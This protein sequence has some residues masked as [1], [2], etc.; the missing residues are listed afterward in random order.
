MKFTYSLLFY[1][2][3]CLF[4]S[5]CDGDLI[6]ISINPISLKASVIDTN[7]LSK[8]YSVKHFDKYVE[9]PVLQK[10]WLEKTVYHSFSSPQSEDK[11]FVKVKG[12]KYY[13]A[14]IYFSIFNKNNHLIFIDSFPMVDALAY[15]IE[16]DGNFGTTLEKERYLEV[17]V[18]QLLD[19]RNIKPKTETQTEPVTGK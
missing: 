14:Q 17:Y 1:F 6:R 15:G 9:K 7:M 11:F 19:S 2:T 13:N 4:I 8:I 3:I 12:D 16:G 18:N 5:S 10:I